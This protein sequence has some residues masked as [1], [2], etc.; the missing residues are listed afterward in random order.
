MTKYDLS[1]QN[2]LRL[3]EGKEHNVSWNKWSEKWMKKF[4]DIDTWR[5]NE[6]ES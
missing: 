4:I 2:I 6:M 5:Q 3:Q 1:K